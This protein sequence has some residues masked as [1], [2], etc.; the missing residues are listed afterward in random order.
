MNRKKRRRL[1]RTEK[2]TAEIV[3]LL[4]IG[5]LHDQ[6]GFG[7]VRIERF[8]N[9]MNAKIEDLENLKVSDLVE[10]IEEVTGWRIQI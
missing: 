9:A 5:V 10:E 1:D 4:S 3:T 7:S 6:F 2:K 8:M